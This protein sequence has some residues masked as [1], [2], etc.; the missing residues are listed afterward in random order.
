MSCS[1]GETGECGNPSELQREA[2]FSLGDS[3]QESCL[4]AFPPS[5]PPFSALWGATLIF[6]SHTAR[7]GSKEIPLLKLV[8]QL[9]ALG[10]AAQ[11]PPPRGGVPQLLLFLGREKGKQR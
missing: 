11:H 2:A 1:T 9:E 8:K 7:L 5:L 4:E 6:L 3:P 10:A